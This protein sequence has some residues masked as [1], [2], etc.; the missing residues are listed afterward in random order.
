[1]LG[2]R[3]LVG[4]IEIFQGEGDI[5]RKTLQQ[6]DQLGREGSS[7][8]GVEDKHSLRALAI[9]QRQDRGRSYAGTAGA[10]VP[11]PGSLVGQEVLGDARLPGPERV[12]S[13]AAP[14]RQRF[15]SRK[16]QVPHLVRVWSV[17]GNDTKEFG[18]GFGE[19]NRRGVE[20]CAMHRGLTDQFEELCPRLG[21][22][23]RFVGRTESCEHPRQTLLLFISFRVLLCAVEIVECKRDVLR[24][25]R[26][27]RDN[28]FIRCPGFADKGHQYADAV[29]G[30]D[31]RKRN[32]SHDSAL[33]S[34]L[35]PG[36]SLRRVEDIGIDARLLRSKRGPANTGP[37]D[38]VRIDRKARPRNQFDNFTRSGDRLQPD[39][40]R[41]REQYHRGNGFSAVNGGITNELIK[42]LRGFGVK[43]C[44]VRSA[45]RAEHPIESS[46]GPLAALACGL[47]IEIVERI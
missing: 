34:R 33:A 44:F 17:R 31:E 22:H 27:Q 46:H 42:L 8:H 19:G 45:Y 40:T 14:F 43:N 23:D 15:R 37:V 39:R 26:K 21:P 25:S 30:F 29:A 18:I 9:K 1:L 3:L 4:A 35:V 28:L 36:L 7:L 10:L 2:L 41:L 6:F 11:G 24:H 32:A 38:I 16:L 47:V 5:L 13:Q 20:L 12:A